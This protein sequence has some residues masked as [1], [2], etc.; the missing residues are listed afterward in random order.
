MENKTRELSVVFMIQK[1]FHRIN[2]KQQTQ[3]N[4]KTWNSAKYSTKGT[5]QLFSVKQKTHHKKS[6]GKLRFLFCI[7]VHEEGAGSISCQAWWVLILLLC[8]APRAG[9]TS[10]LSSAEL[11]SGSPSARTIPLHCFYM[12]SW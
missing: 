5:Q 11:S 1:T 6:L 2:R 10:P 8:S 12:E 9:S 7:Q 3:E 4:I